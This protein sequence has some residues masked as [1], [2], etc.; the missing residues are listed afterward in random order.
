MELRPLVLSL[1]APCVPLYGLITFALKINVINLKYFSQKLKISLSRE[2]T[3]HCN[4]QHC[5]GVKALIGLVC[6]AIF[7]AIGGATS[8][9]RAL[10]PSNTK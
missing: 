6:L 10:Y 9:A 4:E 8:I 1:I 2:K 3:E 5:P 7:G